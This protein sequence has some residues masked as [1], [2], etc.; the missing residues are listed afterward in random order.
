MV[1]IEL[2]DAL[3][4]LRATPIVTAVAALSLA[5]GI[6]ANAALFS[7]LNGLTIKALPVRDP[8]GLALVGDGAWSN[9]LWEELRDRHTHL[10]ARA[11][12]WSNETFD[13]AESGRSEMVDGVY[14]SGDFFETLG[15]APAMGRLL[16]PADD[17]RGGGADGLVAVI[18]H[19]LWE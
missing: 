11:F 3:R 13:L 19:R 12:A 1:S 10:F 16:T 14:A 17:R 15:V 18:S 4:S 8:Q 5:L 2:R 9:P 6:G 7:I